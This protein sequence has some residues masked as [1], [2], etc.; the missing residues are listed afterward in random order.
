MQS[1]SVH[2]FPSSGFSLLYF[3]IILSNTISF[4]DGCQSCLLS[5]IHQRIHRPQQHQSSLTRVATSTWQSHYTQLSSSASSSIF[6]NNNGALFIASL[7]SLSQAIKSRPIV[8]PVMILATGVLVS[9]R[10]FQGNAIF[11]AI[12][13]DEQAEALDEEDDVEEGKISESKPL[14]SAMVGTI[15]I[16]KN[17]IS[18]LLPPACRFLPTCSQYGVQAI[19]EFGPTKGVVLIAWRLLRCSPIGGKGY[20][21]PN[22]PPVPYNYGSY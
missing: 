13:K 17:I 4:V 7:K 21:P 19:E 20:D 12:E 3:L 22:W 1:H 5:P 16:Y 15:G 2:S 6:L 18:P 8:K 14:S 11:K 9:Q 10:V